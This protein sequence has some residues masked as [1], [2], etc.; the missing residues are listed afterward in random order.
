[1]L[2][3]DAFN[4]TLQSKLVCVFDFPAGF[5][6]SVEQSEEVG[7]LEVV[8]GVV[9]V[10]GGTV[11]FVKFCGKEEL[12]LIAQANDF[13]VIY[14]FNINISFPFESWIVVC[15]NKIGEESNLSLL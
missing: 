5:V 6:E 7:M 14:L 3:N 4:S 1:M 9:E 12:T 11:E 15:S 13:G 2:I 8:E 10:E